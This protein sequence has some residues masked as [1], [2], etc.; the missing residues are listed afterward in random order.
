MSQELLFI[1]AQSCGSFRLKKQSIS[2]CKDS[3][4]LQKHLSPKDFSLFLDLHEKSSHQPKKTRPLL[5]RLI[6]QY[7]TLPELYNLLAFVYIKLKKIKKADL[8]LVAAY[9]TCPDDLLTKINYADY[10]LRH[11]KIH[12]VLPIFNGHKDLR[13]LYP[14]KNTFHFTEFRGFMVVMSYFHLELKDKEK[15][16]QYLYLAQKVAPKHPSVVLLQKKLYKTPFLK[17]AT[18]FFNIK[19]FF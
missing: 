8:T 3:T 17:K 2:F 11:R 18:L 16:L 10:C 4:H 12:E 13:D 14:S 6:V 9:K 7:P 1:P 5:E 19:N 15:A